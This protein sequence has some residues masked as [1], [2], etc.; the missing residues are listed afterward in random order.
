MCNMLYMKFSL[1]NRIFNKKLIKGFPP[2]TDCPA[3]NSDCNKPCGCGDS[4]AGGCGSGGSG[5][6]GAGGGGGGGGA[7]SSPRG[8]TSMPPAPGN[9]TEEVSMEI[10][11]DPNFAENVSSEV[12]EF[13]AVGQGGV[14]YNSNGI[15]LADAG[16]VCVT[17]PR[18]QMF[19]SGGCGN[20]CGPACGGGDGFSFGFG[21]GNPFINIQNGNFNFNTSIFGQGN[22]NNGVGVTITY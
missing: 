16:P 9:N 6:G 14:P 4:G 12:E 10:F 20:G 21:A 15:P 8:G 13:L 18:D 17:I 2:C 3:P 11:D 22:G 19:G 5:P 7:G 1:L